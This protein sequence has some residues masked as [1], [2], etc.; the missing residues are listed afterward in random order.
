MSTFFSQNLFALYFFFQHVSVYLQSLSLISHVYISC[1]FWM[2][3]VSFFWKIKLRH[4]LLYNNCTIQC[5]Y[6]VKTNSISACT[7]SSIVW[8]YYVTITFQTDI[9]LEYIRVCVLL[10]LFQV[11]LFFI[12]LSH[13]ALLAVKIFS[14]WPSFC[15]LHRSSLMLQMKFYVHIHVSI[16]F[17]NRQNK[18]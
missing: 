8:T 13:L 9:S 7:L 15:F 2:V 16:D 1:L 11:L 4:E 6:I 14:F 10:V 12:K 3:S 5:K 17:I 18:L